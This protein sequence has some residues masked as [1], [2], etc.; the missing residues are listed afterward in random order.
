LFKAKESS[1]I[2]KEVVIFITPRLIHEDQDPFFERHSKI[3][4]EKELKDLQ[5]KSV[6]SEGRHPPDQ[7]SVET[8]IERKSSDAH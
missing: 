2:D 8:N 1:T 6:H 7:N 4:V 5:E 3:S